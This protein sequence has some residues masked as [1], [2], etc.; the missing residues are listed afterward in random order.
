[1]YPKKNTLGKEC[2]KAQGSICI[3]YFKIS[4]HCYSNSSSVIRNVGGKTSAWDLTFS[5]LHKS[6]TTVMPLCFSQV[7]TK[8]IIVSHF[9]LESSEKR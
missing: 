8:C 6:T 9:K 4:S 5:A 2:G 3:I 7:W 1:M